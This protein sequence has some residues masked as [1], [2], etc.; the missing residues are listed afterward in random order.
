MSIARLCRRGKSIEYIQWCAIP[1]QMS[2]SQAA[3]ISEELLKPRGNSIFE[4]DVVR[5]IERDAIGF[6]GCYLEMGKVI[7]ELIPA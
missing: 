3:Q 1:A 5:Q 7:H 2:W 4:C 6:L